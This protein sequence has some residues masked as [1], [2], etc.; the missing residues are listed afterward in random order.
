MKIKLKILSLLFAISLIISPVL[1]Y[2][3]N[4]PPEGATRIILTNKLNKEQNFKLIVTK[5]IDD[6]WQIASKDLEYG[7]IETKPKQL[8]QKSRIEMIYNFVVKDYQI[9]LS[10]KQSNYLDYNNNN[11]VVMR[12]SWDD[13]Y[14]SVNFNIFQPAFIL[15]DFFDI[16]LNPKP[17]NKEYK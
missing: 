15:M 1:L 3:Q 13:I 14:Y 10:G 6:G 2:G 4:K 11:V 12:S 17:T 5:L 8:G 16:T 7:T 9:I